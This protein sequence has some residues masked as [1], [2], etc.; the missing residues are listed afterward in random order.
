M[1]GSDDTSNLVNLTA[2]EHY[3]AHLLLVKIAKSNNNIAIYKKTLYAFNCMK[4]GRRRGRRSFKFNSRLYQKIKIEYSKL[5]CGMMKTKSNP[6]R[7]RIWIHSMELKQNKCWNK[8]LPIPNGWEKGRVINWDNYL[9]YK[10]LKQHHISP[11]HLSKAEQLLFNAHKVE[12]IIQ[13]RKQQKLKKQINTSERVK[14]IQEIA[15]Y[16]MEYGYE[17]T[18]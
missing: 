18:K 7:N 10:K 13:G 6:M 2:R 17:K 8:E 16:Y 15:N 5:R 11:N 1:G 4:W 14:Q 3:I 12:E 9:D